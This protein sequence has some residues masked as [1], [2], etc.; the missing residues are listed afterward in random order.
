MA[1]KDQE[2]DALFRH[3]LVGVDLDG[4]DASVTP[5]S[6]RAVQQARWL[7][8]R[9]GARVELFHSVEK[10]LYWDPVGAGHV[11]VGHDPGERGGAALEALVRELRDA[12]VPCELRLHDERA[13]LA[14]VREVLRGSVDLVIV[15]KRSRDSADGRQLGSVSKKLLRKCPCPVWVVRPDVDPRHDV[16]LAA[17]DLTPVG[18]RAV[19]LAASLVRASGGRLHVVHAWQIPLQL[20]MGREPEA[21]REQALAAIQERA[22]EH[23]LSR[24]RAVDEDVRPEL[25]VGCDSPT[26]AIRRGVE[27]LQPEVLVM[28]TISRGGVAGVLVGNTAEALLDRVEC[29]ILTVKPPDFVCPVEAAP[30]VRAD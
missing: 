18:D 17:T 9:T 15:G 12:G 16:V 8:E 27:H 4:H 26:R 21:E 22:G 11:V 14:M 19:E 20:Q 30:D 5:G 2:R 3:I 29:A 7:A 13:W 23:I 25:H 6:R 10:D 1:S 28:G 24:L